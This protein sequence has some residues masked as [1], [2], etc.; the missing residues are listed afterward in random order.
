M[1]AENCTT[2]HHA[3]ECREAKFA[4]LQQ[5]NAQLEDHIDKCERLLRC[6]TKPRGF[7]DSEDLRLETLAFLY[8]KPAKIQIDADGLAAENIRLRKA[9]A[10]TQK[11][12]GIADQEIREL[13]AKLQNQ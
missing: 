10:N 7:S 4:A 5:E 6:W 8:G 1:N 11:L 3:C 12:I 9:L 13:K 2:H